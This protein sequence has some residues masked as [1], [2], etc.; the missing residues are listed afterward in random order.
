MAIDPIFIS[1]EDVPEFAAIGGADTL[2]DDQ[3]MRLA[4]VRAAES[5]RHADVRRAQDRGAAECLRAVLRGA[6]AAGSPRAGEFLAYT[7]RE[8]WWLKDY[9]LFRALHAG[10]EERS[11]TEWDASIK[12]RQP[13]AMTEAGSRLEREILYYQWLQW[14]AGEQWAA[15]RAAA[16]IAILGD[17][18]FMVSSDSADV[19]ARQHEFGWIRQ[20]AYRRTR[21]RD[22]PGLGSPG[23]PMEILQANGYEWLCQ[24]A[25]RCAE[26]FDGFRVDHLVGFYRTY[27][28][29]KDGSTGFHP[30]DETS[31]LAQGERLL[32]S[33]A[34][35]AA[36]SSRKISDRGG[37]RP[38][39]ARPPRRPRF[40]GA[41]RERNWK[42]TA[43]HSL[44]HNLSRGVG[45]DQRHA[46]H[47]DDGRCGGAGRRGGTTGCRR[48]AAPE[49]IGDP[50]DDP[51]SD[52]V[53]DALLES[54]FAA[55][56][57]LLLVPVQD[58]F[59]WCDRIN[60]RRSSA[61]RTGRGGCLDP[62]RLATEPKALERAEF[63]RR[64]VHDTGRSSG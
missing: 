52:R 11:W 58:L 24:R 4:A 12:E 64:L 26:L 37:V 56:S 41:A 36:A 43:N 2:T 19:W 54:L 40:E 44:I 35:T 33:S 18:P 55:R 14:L 46:R 30:P 10:Y 62:D 57:E 51:F 61:T 20:S 38:R 42:L 13:G 15:A 53:R 28:R 16:G 6:A 5:V 60:V 50:A 39:V 59:G 25:T 1:V 8:A 22:R 48:G 29:E 23:L 21:L 3:Q 9:A 32:T 31:Q 27:V 17:F 45:R 34:H 7:E 47:R 49:K 63:I